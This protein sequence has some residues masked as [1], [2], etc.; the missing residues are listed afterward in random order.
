MTASATDRQAMYLASVLKGLHSGWNPH[1]TQ[2]LVLNAVFQQGKRR[3]G[4]ECGRKWGKTDIVCYILWRFSMMLS[5]ADNYYF[6]PTS[7]QARELIWANR[8]LQEFGPRGFISGKPNETELRMRFKT[9]SFIKLA[10]S[11]N[12]DSYRGV[13]PDVYV[14]DE[15]K[16]FHPLFHPAMEPNEG[17]KAGKDLGIHVVVGTPPEVD[18]HP[19]DPQRGHPFYELM[20][21]I[22]EDPDGAYFNFSTYDN[23]HIP[24]HWIDK[25]KEKY[26]KR[27]DEAGFMR[28]HMAKRIKGGPGAIFPMWDREKFVFPHNLI[29]E[30]LSRDKRNIQ[31]YVVADP[32]TETVFAVLFYAINPYTNMVYILDEIYAK[33]QSETSTS[34][35]I[36][37][38][39]RAR[40]ELDY[41]DYTQI[42]DEAE[43]W[44]S[45]EASAS[46]SESF[47]PTHKS[48]S[49]KAEGLSLIKDQMLN[50]KVMISDRCKNLVWEISNYVKDKNGNI[51]KKHDHLIDCWRYGNAAAGLSLE[52]SDIPD[53]EEDEDDKQNKR[54]TLE[55]ERII[56]DPWEADY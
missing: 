1:M 19:T 2:R 11:E 53:H 40:R 5:N 49:S 31:K 14:Y 6:G 42:Y 23:P 16:D 4:I 12:F 24:S 33:S 48:W 50:V 26:I 17:A 44:F 3:I 7:V 41:I 28:E 46:F 25:Q 18:S 29:M 37:K 34:V 22:K 21:E 9:G 55:S 47:L 13:E 38:I 32:G 15:F 8:R 43:A 20:D 52:S 30:K 54:F 36:P 56:L 39:I 51:P 45:N 27:G 35:I 10:G